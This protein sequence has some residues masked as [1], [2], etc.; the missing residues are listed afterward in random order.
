MGVYPILSR[1]TGVSPL[2][3]PWDRTEN[4]ITPP[5]PPEGTWDQRPG[6][7]T[8]VDGQT[9]YFLTRL[10][11]S[12]LYAGINKLQ[13]NEVVLDCCLSLLD[14]SGLSYR[15]RGNPVQVV[16]KI[17]ALVSL[18]LIDYFLTHLY[19]KATVKSTLLHFIQGEFPRRQRSVSREMVRRIF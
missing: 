11:P 12:Y 3:G 9:H 8:P 10:N 17:A 15:M 16:R 13:F 19:S 6:V 18:R 1:G 2:E 7:P 4:D 14:K 5:P